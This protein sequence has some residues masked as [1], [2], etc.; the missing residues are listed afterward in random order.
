[1]K[2]K[3]LLPYQV[4]A[5]IDGVERIVAETTQGSFGLLPRRLD[6]VAVLEPGILTYETKAA[7]EIYIAVDEGILVKVGAD[8]LVSVRNAIG[9]TDLGKLRVAVAKEF[10]DLD[11]NEKQVRAVLARFRTPFHGVSSWLTI[12]KTNHPAMAQNSSARSA[13]RK[14]ANS[15]RSAKSPVRSGLAWA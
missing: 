5:E 7:G 12:P 11:E 8:V 1:M 6:C 10:V 4:Y 13:Q 9:G 15:G 3:V 2:L 14:H